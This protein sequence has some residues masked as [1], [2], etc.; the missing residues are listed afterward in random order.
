MRLIDESDAFCVL[1][2]YYHHKTKEQSESLK[3][4]LSRVPTV[5]AV[6][7]VR[8]KD[9]KECEVRNTANYLPFLFCKHNGHSVSWAEY[10]SWGEWVAVQRR[11]EQC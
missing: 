4:A 11:E 2:D 3:E 10:C 9:C 8:C 5:D 6:P 7:V 1:T